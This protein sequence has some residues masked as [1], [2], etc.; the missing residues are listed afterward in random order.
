M[1]RGATTFALWEPP[2]TSLT[3]E[4]GAPVRRAATAESADLLADLAA[5]GART[6]AFLE[7]GDQAIACTTGVRS[8][9]KG[10]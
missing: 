10:G 2:L 7:R 1:P 3:G 5:C 9:L 6:L 8:E 4:N